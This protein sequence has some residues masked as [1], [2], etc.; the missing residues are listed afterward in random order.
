MNSPFSNRRLWTGLLLGL[1]IVNLAV[2]WP[3]TKGSD[4]L[5]GRPPWQGGRVPR[6]RGSKPLWPVFPKPTVRRCR[7]TW[8]PKGRFS[9]RS[10]TLRKM[11]AG[12]RC[13]SISQRTRPL[14]FRAWDVPPSCP[15]ATLPL[16]L[17]SGRQGGRR[18]DRRNLPGT[19]P[20]PTGFRSL[21]KDGRWINSSLT[22]GKTARLN[23]ER[24]HSFEP[25][26]RRI[27]FR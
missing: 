15:L 6:G 16:C 27:Q 23:H 18:R 8:Q 17:R 7:S 21:W 14:R 3:R 11:I 10:R 5:Y 1:L 2:Y 25:K 9:R 12:K 22:R 4:E 26:S 20:A 24:P 13:K 19:C